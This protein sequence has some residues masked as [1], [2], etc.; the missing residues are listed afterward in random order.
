M[1]WLGDRTRELNSAHVEYLSGIENPIG[2]KCGPNIDLIDL[3][4]IIRK[5]NPINEKGKIVLI[6]RFGA[7]NIKR[8]ATT[9][10]HD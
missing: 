6:C 2:I 8:I 3:E 1:V 5:L 10:K 4:S 7:K 9:N